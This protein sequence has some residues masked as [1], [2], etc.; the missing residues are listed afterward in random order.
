MNR[1]RVLNI[2]MLILFTLLV[3]G[4]LTAKG[5]PTDT[6][7]NRT[8]YGQRGGRTSWG[9]GSGMMG[10]DYG[11]PVYANADRL[12]IHDVE[13]SLVDYVKNYFGSDFFI[14][15]IMEFEEN[16]YAQVGKTGEDFLSV[17]L[18][19]DPYNGRIYP[20]YGPNMMWNRSYGHM[21]RGFWNI[22]KNKVSA[23]EAVIMAQEY[24]DGYNSGL[25]ADEHPAKFDGYYTLHTLDNKK[26]VGMLSVNASNGDIWYHDWHGEYLGSENSGHD[27]DNDHND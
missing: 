6:N 27:D 19:I 21:R 16:Y 3:T 5:N 15:E 17:E 7:Y 23:E 25:T 11:P 13:E 10:R 24:L 8:E 14:E 20:E 26:I 22:G 9:H 2:I 12:S 4:F 18:L 1:K